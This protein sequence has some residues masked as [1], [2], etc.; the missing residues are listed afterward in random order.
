MTSM[1]LPSIFFVGTNKCQNH[2]MNIGINILEIYMADKGRLK[3]QCFK[4]DNYIPVDKCK[5]TI[6][7]KGD[8]ATK[9]NITLDT[10]LS[11]LTEE[12]EVDAP[13]IEYSLEEESNEI[14]YSCLLYTSP[15]PRDLSTSRMPSSA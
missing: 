1:K 12:L 3:V 11:G 7:G 13:P 10:D 9:S 2:I 5:V 6:E 15:S 4:E 14:P 8:Y